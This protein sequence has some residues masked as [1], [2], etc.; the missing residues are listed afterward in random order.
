[1]VQSEVQTG[2]NGGGAVGKTIP[3]GMCSPLTKSASFVAVFWIFAI[4]SG[5]CPWLFVFCV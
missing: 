2:K 3:R 5:R 1:M 4:F